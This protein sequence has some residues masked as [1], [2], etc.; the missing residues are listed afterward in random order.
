LHDFC[1]DLYS[2]ELSFE[3]DKNWKTY[4]KLVN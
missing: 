3:C 4:S 2:F 1:G